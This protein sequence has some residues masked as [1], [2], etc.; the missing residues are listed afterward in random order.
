MTFKELALKEELQRAIEEMGFVEATEIQAQAIP[1]LIENQIDFIGLAQT[2]TGKTAAFGLPLLQVIDP[3]LRVPQALIVCPTREL[4]L[5]ITKE[6]QRFAKF[7]KGMNV[8]A[9]YGGASINDQLYNLKRGVHIVVGTPGRLMDHIERRSLDLTQ[10]KT[11]VLDEADEMLNMGF[12]EDIDTIL[13]K[14]PEEKSTWLFSATMSA[15]I[16]RITKKYMESPVRVTV[17]SRNS[18][19]KTIE[20]QYCVVKYENAYHALRRFIDFYPELYGL[21]FCKTKKETAEIA[22][23]LARDGY[24]V[25]TIHGDLSQFQ[26]DSV[27]KK[28]REKSI[29][30]LIATD[31]AARGIDVSDITHVFHYNLPQDIENYTH[32]SGRTGRAG[33][34]G[35][36]IAILNTREARQVPYI[37]RTIGTKITHTQVPSGF[38]VC[39]KQLYHFINT[40][41]NVEV[42]KDAIAP[43]LSR[44]QAE[45]QDLSKEALLEKLVSLE[46][47]TFLR[48]YENAPNLNASLQKPLDGKGYSPKFG[49]SSDEKP[50]SFAQF[51][52]N[53]GKSDGVE[54]GQL[55]NFVCR[56]GGIRGQVLGKIKITPDETY[57]GIAPE[58]VEKIAKKLSGMEFKNT[59]IRATVVT[60]A[61]LETPSF[62]YAPRKHTP[63]K[64]KRKY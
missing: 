37:E 36:S 10:I 13:G 9:V 1:Q 4:C 48:A 62:G 43:Y 11:V 23:K 63:Y 52:I 7:Q 30:L 12:K 59:S 29:K 54:V 15:E 27:M 56:N 14:T 53:V 28:F 58:L 8:G 21:L 17:G 3:A 64:G 18:S 57:I 16:E 50:G 55:I 45:F 24:A 6:L 34:T 51:K 20:H 60:D 33:K 61:P 49:G 38:E 39:E 2:G 32:R 31:V 35:I 5:Q 25:D 42:K 44:I 40:V 46:F 22:E 26:R 19:S 41:H 47:N